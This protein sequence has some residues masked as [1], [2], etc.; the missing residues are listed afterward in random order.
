[1]QSKK[2]S[3]ETTGGT[4]IFRP[5]RYFVNQATREAALSERKS[6]AIM[7]TASERTISSPRRQR[8]CPEA[9]LMW[10]LAPALMNSAFHAWGN[11]K[12]RLQSMNGSFVLATTTARKGSSRRRAA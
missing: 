7:P 3:Q 10:P 6:E 4:F 11:S 8:P 2:S 5:G 1:M 12:A 9:T